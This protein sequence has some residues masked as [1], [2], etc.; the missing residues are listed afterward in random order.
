MPCFLLLSNSPLGTGIMGDLN[1]LLLWGRRVSASWYLE[2]QKAQLPN[3]ACA[4]NLFPNALLTLHFS[5]KIFKALFPDRCRNWMICKVGRW[6]YRKIPRNVA[7][8]LLFICQNSLS[9]LQI[10]RLIIWSLS[11]QNFLW[12]TSYAVYSCWIILRGIPFLHF[13]LVPKSYQ[14]SLSFR[15]R[16][17]FFPLS[18]QIFLQWAQYIWVFA[19]FLFSIY[20]CLISCLYSCSSP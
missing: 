6:S 14:V 19:V 18:F 2:A 1:L 17:R 20:I 7:F 9:Y 16:S 10:P 13:V 4:R 8:P 12:I 5:Y 15:D 11:C 3:L